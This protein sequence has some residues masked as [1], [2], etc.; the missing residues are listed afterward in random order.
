MATFFGIPE[1]QD[2]PDWTNVSFDFL[3]DT[4]QVQPGEYWLIDDYGLKRIIRV[5]SDNPWSNISVCEYYDD[6]PDKIVDLARRHFRRKASALELLAR[7]A[8]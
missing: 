2:E 8:D 4:K 5:V 1:P 7:E 3:A 6:R